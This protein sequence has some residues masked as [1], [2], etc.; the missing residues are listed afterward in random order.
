MH[1]RSESRAWSSI[2]ALYRGGC[3]G[4]SEAREG[5]DTIKQVATFTGGLNLYTTAKHR[6]SPIPSALFP[7]MCVCAILKGSSLKNDDVTSIIQD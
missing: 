7:K 2:P 3:G 6:L 5:D 4:G 1:K